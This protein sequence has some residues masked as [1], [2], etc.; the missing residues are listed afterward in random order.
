M[1]VLPRSD[2]DVEDTWSVSGLCGTGSHDVVV[3]GSFVPDELSFV[4]G[5]E[6]SVDMAPL[7]IPEMTR[8]AIQIASV[9]IG[10]AQ[11]AVDDILSLSL[12]KTPAFARE[13][14]ASNPLFQ[15]QLGEAETQLRATRAA[16]HADADVVWAKAQANV[17]LTAEDRAHVRGTTTWIARTT[18]A[19][20]TAAYQAGGSSSISTSNPLQRRLRDAHALTQHLTMK[21]D[22]FTKVGAVL[23]G[24]EVDLTLF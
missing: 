20:V 1:M 17:P 4:I 14:L 8:A 13:P 16:L 19:V 3:D 7:R 15:T 9:T 10:V 24:Q 21:A 18:A 12:G 5:D 23:A 22:T 11:G 2:F 6:P